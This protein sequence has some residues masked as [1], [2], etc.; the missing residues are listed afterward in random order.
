[1]MTPRERV[2]AA[3]NHQSPDQTPM[4]FGGTLMSECTSEFLGKFREF[5]G[6]P[7]PD[8]RHEPDTWLDESIS[9]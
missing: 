8:D 7:L 1:M 5:M 6:T 2:L 3:I 9:K 4:D